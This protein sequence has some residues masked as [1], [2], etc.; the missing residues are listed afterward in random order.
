MY[1][2]RHWYILI[3]G[4]NTSVTI[5]LCSTT[6]SYKLFAISQQLLLEDLAFFGLDLNGHSETR[7]LHYFYK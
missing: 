6:I 4:I 5:D 1:C 3:L 2:Q 7:N